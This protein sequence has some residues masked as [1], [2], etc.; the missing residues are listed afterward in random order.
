MK[1]IRYTFILITALIWAV[2]CS[3]DGF[4]PDNSGKITAIGVKEAVYN[5]SGTPSMQISVKNNEQLQLTVFIMP[6]DAGNKKLEY[7]NLHPELLE[8]DGEGL[9]KGKAIGTDTL[10]ISATDGSG[11]HVSFVVKITG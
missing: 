1:K 5:S 3:P 8:V 11:T 2:G 4:D 7:S 10:T 9:L 6:Q